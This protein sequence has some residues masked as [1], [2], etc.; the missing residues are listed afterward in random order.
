MRSIRELLVSVALLIAG[1]MMTASWAA[2]PVSLVLNFRNDGTGV[3]PDAKP[4]L[5][6]K[7]CTADPE[8]ALWNTPLP[9]P[10]EI[11]QP[12]IAGDRIIVL[13]T[14]FTLTCLDK[15]SGK[16]LWQRKT[17][18]QAESAGEE[19]RKAFLLERYVRYCEEKIIAR[20]GRMDPI[21]RG[22]P[23]TR[24]ERYVGVHFGGYRKAPKDQHERLKAEYA[25][26]L[27]RIPETWPNSNAHLALA[28][29]GDYDGVWQGVASPVTDGVHVWGH[30]VTGEI[31]CYDLNGGRK[32][33]RLL[34][35]Y[36]RD[37]AASPLSNRNN[38]CTGIGYSNT[39]PL[40]HDGRIYVQR[41]RW[42]EGEG[43]KPKGKQIV[44]MYCQDAATG[45]TVW[46]K[47]IQGPLSCH[48]PVAVRQNVSSYIVTPT[49][50][51]LRPD[52][53]VLYG[54]FWGSMNEAA[55][56]GV[57]LDRTKGTVYLSGA[58]RMPDTPEGRPTVLWS[59]KKINVA[60]L[61]Q[62][63]PAGEAP[64]RHSD[65]ALRRERAKAAP[66]G[67]QGKRGGVRNYSAP[68]VHRGIFCHFNSTFKVVSASDVSKDVLEEMF[69]AEPLAQLASPRGCVMPRGS[70]LES[71]FVYTDLIIAGDYLFVHGW[72]H[73]AI[74]KTGKAFQLVAVCPHEA[75]MSNLVFDGERMYLR[76]LERLWCF[77]P[78]APRVRHAA[79]T[80][81][82]RVRVQFDQEVESRGAE[83]T[84]A[85]RLGDGATVTTVALGADR[86]SV[87]LTVK[88][89]PDSGDLELRVAGITG[90]TGKVAGEI[91]HSF[92]VEQRLGLVREYRKGTPAKKYAWRS[93]PVTSTAEVIGFA[94]PRVRQPIVKDEIAAVLGVTG[95]AMPRDQEPGVTIFEGM[96]H[97]AVAGKYQFHFGGVT[98]AMLFLNGETVGLRRD[99][100]IPLLS[101]L[102]HALPAGDHP[103]RLEVYSSATT[104]LKVWW[105]GPGL[106]CEETPTSV[107]WHASVQGR[108]PEATAA[109][110]VDYPA[111]AGQFMETSD[112]ALLQTLWDPDSVATVALLKRKLAD[113]KED[114][115]KSIVAELGRMTVDRRPVLPALLE[116]LRSGKDPWYRA[117]AA[118]A[119]A[120]MGPRA[121]AA[122]PG[123]ITAL[124]DK[125]E[126]VQ[127]Y[128]A[129]ALGAIGPKAKGAIPALEKLVADPTPPPKTSG[130]RPSVAQEARAAIEKIQ[131]AGVN[132]GK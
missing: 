121:E 52:G 127:R 108:T 34:W 73:T 104:D 103:F 3:Y 10:A 100:R 114:A 21:K 94:M 87:D 64:A 105:E 35:E 46:K 95:S 119:I 91:T 107:F 78:T 126:C 125:E 83:Q 101:N 11:S 51:I 54:S 6:W 55:G 57:G 113:S 120:T 53:T 65:V 115:N 49:G 22:R 8:G 74:L 23:I 28:C 67:Q 41:Q 44:I 16:V 99:R 89:L 68:V 80:N 12:V 66:K 42:V 109:P 129:N 116:A 32:W 58:A 4:P 37:P 59:S 69:Y 79:T 38:Q 27:A 1:I 25:A 60:W 19:E 50:V 124:A 96:L 88:G 97:I 118:G 123:L 18:A 2:E 26:L 82:D 15:M 86:R 20:F 132:R 111:L 110:K 62:H 92:R 61:A 40:L 75:S 122:V 56:P 98:E 93:L 81:P 117:T 17:H 48:G 30:F 102:P 39:T 112:P 106:E 47:P 72:K 13:S 33:L 36:Q 7:A 130:N 77:A 45:A 90:S 31:V 63:V 70:Q 85:Y 9:G 131:A 76:S 43:T 29:N 24:E 84:A 14:P 71:P 128:A 5:R